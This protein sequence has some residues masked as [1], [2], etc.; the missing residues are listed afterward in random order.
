M[1]ILLSKHGIPA[2]NATG[3]GEYAS[4]TLASVVQGQTVLW[5]KVTGS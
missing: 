2:A 3:F 1:T 4:F 5:Y